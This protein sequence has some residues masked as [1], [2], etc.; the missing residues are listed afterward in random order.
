MLAVRASIPLVVRKRFAY[1]VAPGVSVDAVRFSFRDG[2]VEY[3]SV[4]WL[5]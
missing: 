5:S 2:V 4:K 1:V 3:I